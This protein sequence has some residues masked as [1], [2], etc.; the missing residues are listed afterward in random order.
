[1]TPGRYATAV[2]RAK[3]QDR[4]CRGKV[5]RTRSQGARPVPR[6]C[7]RR[8]S[9]GRTTPSS[10]GSCPWMKARLSRNCAGSSMRNQG[11]AAAMASRLGRVQRK[12]FCATPGQVQAAHQLVEE[13]AAGRCQQCASQCMAE[14]LAT[15]VWRSN[16]PESPAAGPRS[17]R[18][19][20][21]RWRPARCSGSGRCTRISGCA[22]VARR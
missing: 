7:R 3:V 18:P 8:T 4:R 6:R 11:R 16:P 14:L 5:Q 17:V 19:G 21:W 12:C 2:V 13:Q 1:M 20:R 10:A 9:I 15:L 22:S